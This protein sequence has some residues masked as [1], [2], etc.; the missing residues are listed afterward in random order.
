MNTETYKKCKNQF[1]ALVRKA[2]KTYYSNQFTQ[3]SNNIKTTWHLI[4]HLLNRTK[5]PFAAPVEMNGKKGVLS[6]PTDI[7][8]GFNDFFISAGSELASSIDDSDIDPCS[9]I[10][11]Q[12]PPLQNFDPPIL[13]EVRNITLSLKNAAHG[14]DGIKSVLIKETID[15]I[16][17]PF[18]HIISLS[19]KTGIVPQ[20]LK[21][22]KV[23]P[24]FKTGD[25]KKFSNYRPISI[26][27]CISKI[28]S[29]LDYLI[30]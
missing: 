3:A 4:N 9:M 15:Y 16:I 13:Q 30:T 28:L 17:K 19:L 12:Y 27:P 2:K 26:L 6:N 21:I 1:T 5:S 8:N 14:H 23:I 7:A 22:A 29:I 20:D 18:S 24:I 10:K 11:G 25:S